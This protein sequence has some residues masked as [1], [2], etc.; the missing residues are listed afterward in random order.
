MEREQTIQDNQSPDI[1]TY[2]VA[3]THQPIINV[4]WRE[5]SV[6]KSTDCSSKGPITYVAAHNFKSSRPLLV[7]EGTVQHV[8]T[9]KQNSHTYF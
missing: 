6:V 7:S 3:P 5:D 2:T 1:H 9:R 4:G 8:H